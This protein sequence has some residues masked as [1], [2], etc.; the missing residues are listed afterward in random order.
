[1]TI[2]KVFYVF[3]SS[4]ISRLNQAATIIAP[5]NLPFLYRFT[6]MVLFLYIVFGILNL[7]YKNIILLDT[8]RLIYETNTLNTEIKSLSTNISTLSD[9]MLMD[10]YY[11]DSFGLVSQGEILFLV[12]E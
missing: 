11:R 1:M 4:A 9:P 12:V 6:L 8:N 3:L 7:S 2:V 5:V 10:Y